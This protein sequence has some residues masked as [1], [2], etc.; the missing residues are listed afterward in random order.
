MGRLTL[1]DPAEDSRALRTM[2]HVARILVYTGPISWIV[3]CTGMPAAQPQNANGPTNSNAGIITTVAGTGL[4]SF[5]GDGRPATESGLYLPMDVA[6]LPDGTPLILD[7]NNQRIRALE[8]DGTLLTVIGTGFEDISAAG[9]L[10]IGFPLHHC[11]EMFVAGDGQVYLAGYHDPRVLRIDQDQRV[12]VVAGTGDAG[13]TGDDGP[14]DQATLDY[15]SGVAVASDGTVFVADQNNH[16]V[17]RIDSDG[18][19]RRFAGTGSPGYSGDGGPALDAELRGPTRIVF[20]GNGNLLICDTNNHAIRQVDTTGTIRSIAGTGQRG[21]SGDGAA[22]TAA[23][24]DSPYDVQ[25]LPDGSLLIA[26][27]LNHVIRRVE[28]SGAV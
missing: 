17:R 1:E 14:A 19:I 5:T 28:L 20:D 15:P 6:F 18:T 13:D 16:N 26:D 4:A 3:G 25:P 21:Y 24:L 12:H 9:G 8:P 2:L 11:L 7:W 27:S 10:A 23:Q 22:A